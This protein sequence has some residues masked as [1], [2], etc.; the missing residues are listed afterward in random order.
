MDNTQTKSNDTS[1][2]SMYILYLLLRFKWI[3]IA[4][5][6]IVTAAA[7]IIAFRMPNKY[8]ATVNTV[9]PKTSG[10]AFENAMGNLSSALKDFGLT[11]LGGKSE[12]AYSF[13][14]ILDSKSVKDSIIRKYDFRKIYDIEESRPSLV[15][16]QF[17]DNLEITAEA[18]GNYTISFT[19]EDP[20]R[21]AEVANLYVSVANSVSQ[22]LFHEESSVNMLYLEDRLNGINSAINLISDSLQ[23]YSSKKL[24]F[25]PLDQAKSISTA[26]AELK[27]EVMKQEIVEQMMVNRFGADDPYTLQQRT[28]IN[29]LKKQLSSATT[30]P[31]F[32]GNFPV[33]TAAK[34]GMEFMRLYAEF[35]AYNKVK[36]FLLP[37][38]EE[39]KLNVSRNTQTL[40]VVDK[41]LP[42]DRK[43]APKRSLILAGTFMGSFVLIVLIIII[44][45]FFRDVTRKYRSKKQEF[46]S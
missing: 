1:F 31:G 21:A 26:L 10:S 43:S 30:E 44:F 34:V 8:T 38:L 40:F 37:M 35:E 9:P 3:I 24:V 19:D 2:D 32:A 11:K 42:P 22:K 20:K 7:G 25:S 17:E 5:V 6:I 41:A 28:I 14:V 33:N 15:V 46:S 27:A 13:L 39:S 4:F 36:A 16:K 45:D 29:G 12:G 18:E 23:M